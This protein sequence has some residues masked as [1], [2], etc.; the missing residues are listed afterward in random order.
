M[1]W[2]TKSRMG[3]YIGSGPG[4]AF[5]LPTRLIIGLDV[6]MKLELEHTRYM[7]HMIHDTQTAIFINTVTNP[8]KLIEPS[9]EK[10]VCSNVA[11]AK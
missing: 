3:V 11:N 1:L 5:P 2:F 4:T 9:A 10:R 8:I 7:I 6:I